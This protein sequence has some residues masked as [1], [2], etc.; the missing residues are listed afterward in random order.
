MR[1]IATAASPIPAACSGYALAQ[2]DRGED[3]RH[4]RV[5]RGQHRGDRERAA[6]TARM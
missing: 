2:E 6:W 5:Q 4:D 3:H 1:T